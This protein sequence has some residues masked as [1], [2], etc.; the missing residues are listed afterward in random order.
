[1][2]DVDIAATLDG[3]S[4]VAADLM[5]QFVLEGTLSGDSSVASDL[6]AQFVL[7]GS[8]S[9]DSSVAADLMAQFVLQAALSGTS[10]LTSTLTIL[11]TD[12]IS[13]S[14]DSGISAQV[15]MRYGLTAGLLG[16]SLVDAFPTWVGAP[17]PSPTTPSS[18]SAA[19]LQQF[20]DAL[21][22]GRSASKTQTS[23]SMAVDKNPP[24]KPFVPR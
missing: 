19:T 6:V 4:S 16:G 23:Q 24:T 9:G 22:N 11:D 7:E 15:S 8:L 3:D 10:S 5:A 14:G 21:G 2:A 12:T 13:F 17:R 18:N 1:M 20:I